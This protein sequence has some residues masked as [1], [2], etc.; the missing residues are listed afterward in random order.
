MTNT[1]RLVQ[2]HD[3]VCD[4]PGDS[5]SDLWFIYHLGRRLKELY[6]GSTRTTGSADPGVDLGLS[7]QRADGRT[8]CRLGAER[9]QRLHRRR[10][11]AADKLPGNQGRRQHGLRRLDVQRRL[12]RGRTTTAA[13]PASRMARTVRAAI[14]VGRYAWPDNRRTLY[15]RASADPDGQ[16]VVGAQ[17]D[18]L[19]G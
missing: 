7:G 13:A 2:W 15:N 4:P 5:R 9:D 6:A 16:T 12:S 10:P 8:R 17:A 19:V 3:K 14:R 1:S 11:Q 18:D